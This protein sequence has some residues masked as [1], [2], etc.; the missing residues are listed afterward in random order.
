MSLPCRACP[1]IVSRAYART[2]QITARVM[3]GSS[4]VISSANH[5]LQPCSNSPSRFVSRRL[6]SRHIRAPLI[7]LLPDAKQN[8]SATIPSTGATSDQLSI[9]QRNIPIIPP[10]EAQSLNR[11]GAL[12][13]HLTAVDQL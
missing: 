12:A 1:L 11:P 7:C 9:K 8:V 10:R 4:R 3:R 2:N 13:C 5:S 6:W